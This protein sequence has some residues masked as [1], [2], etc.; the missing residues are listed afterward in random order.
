MIENKK[1]LLMFSSVFLMAAILFGA[2]IPTLTA[3]GTEEPTLSSNQ[4][5]MTALK[6]AD[7]NTYYVEVFSNII[8]CFPTTVTLTE[9]GETTV[10]NYPDEFAGAYIDASNNLHI[11]LTNS[12]YVKTEYDYQK[13]TGYDKDVVFNVA[14][15]SLSFLYD[16]QR[17]LGDVM[18][19]LGIEG[20][21]LNEVTNKLEVHMFDGAKE[22]DVVEF[23]K[24]KFDKFNDQCLDFKG[25]LG[26]RTTASNTASNAL[27][28]SKCTVPSGSATLGFNAYRSSEGKYG[29]VTAAHVATSGTT[30]K[31]ALGTTIGSASVRQQS[32]TVD[33]AFIPFPSGISQSYKLCTTSVDD[34]I[35]GYRTN[36]NIVQGM[37][38]RK[39]G[40]TTGYTTG[41][42]RSVTGTITVGGT[43]Y[44]DQVVVSNTQLN[45]DS[46]GP[47]LDN[48][49]GPFPSKPYPC[50]LI[51]IATI[52]D[53]SNYGY[54][55]KVGNVMSSLGITPYTY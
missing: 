1:S 20:I 46:G 2:F 10:I 11:V 42:V 31:N 27:A 39:Y 28:G 17:T 22:T 55:S 47:V 5:D 4:I 51:G 37:A 3:I 13:I 15:F 50:S 52:A 54:A 40:I 53:S 6:T 36:A 43:P 21:I 9:Y 16:V 8:E 25:P 41:T 23:L 38:T 45:G 24:T 29:V 44:T 48:M 33:A 26:L 7:R 14:E 19:K 18:V 34:D 12:V 49:L 32:G 35:T 30:V